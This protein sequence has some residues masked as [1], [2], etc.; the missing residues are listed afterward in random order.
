MSML[1]GSEQ[2]NL[3][4]SLRS[5]F[6]IVGGA[7]AGTGV[8]GITFG[9]IWSPT[10]LGFFAERPVLQNFELVVPFLPIFLIALGASLFVRS[11]L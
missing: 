6:M 10:V 3:A 2:A 7:S 4:D 11:R 9:S 8:F 5:L 1:E